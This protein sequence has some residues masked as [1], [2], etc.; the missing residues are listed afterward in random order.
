MAEREPL[1]S[2]PGRAVQPSAFACA[3]HC[4]KAAGNVS[5]TP[6]PFANLS[7]DLAHGIAVLP[8]PQHVTLATICGTLTKILPT[9]ACIL[10][11]C[12][13]MLLVQV[14]YPTTTTLQQQV[15]RYKRPGTAPLK[16]QTA[17]LDR[18]T[19]KHTAPWRWRVTHPLPAGHDLGHEIMTS[20]RDNM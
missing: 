11:L 6:P 13:C 19:G 10:H 5:N 2:R 17:L 12:F 15:D 8:M 18:E 16:R 14:L 4:Q 7:G 20:S 3:C 1:S 9:L